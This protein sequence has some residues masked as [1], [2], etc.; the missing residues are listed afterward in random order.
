MRRF[1]T[2]AAA[3]A[4]TA[5]APAVAQTSEEK[6]PTQVVVLPMPKSVAGPASPDA[7]RITTADTSPADVSREAPI[8]GV[9]TLYG[10]QRCPTNAS[11]GEVVV[12]V[13]RGA[14]EQFRVPKDLREFKVTPEN[15]AWATRVQSTLDAGATGIGTC[16]TVG[17]SVA[18]GCFQQQARAAKVDNRERKAEA[19]PDLS[20]Y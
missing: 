14:A 6:R 11:G 13:R 2:R 10:N 5:A 4:V 12:C 19:T 18:T 16:T 20:K 17:P 1:W 8:N 9:L 7:K 3:L 15:A